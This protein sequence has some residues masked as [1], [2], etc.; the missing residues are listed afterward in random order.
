MRHVL[1][2]VLVCT[3]FL[4]P[5]LLRADGVASPV[6]WTA[7]DINGN[8]VRVP[9]VAGA[10]GP[11][12]ILFAMADQPRSRD[13]AKQLTDALKVG[14]ATVVVVVSG[15]NSA[16]GAHRFAAVDGATWPVVADPDYNASGVFN[17][18]VWPTTVVLSQQGVILG[19][20]AGLPK[21]YLSEVEAHIAL[22]AGRIDQAE[23]EHRLAGQ[24]VIGDDPEQMATRHLTVADRLL[25]KGLKREA[26]RELDAALNF[27]PN[28]PQT[29]FAMARVALA[30]GRTD[31]AV[32]ILDSIPHNTVNPAQLNLLRGKALCAQ[33]KW[34]AAVGILC[35]AV[36][37]NPQPAEAW[38][39]LG[40]AYDQLNQP[41]KAAEA[42]RRAF[43][44]TDVGRK[45]RQD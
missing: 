31:G 1:H 44:S 8:E 20:V 9:A 4:T 35:D 22:A 6:N 15:E 11:W 25:D 7:R 21:S 27:H 36:K 33:G 23:L 30:V 43:E 3:A 2:V 14:G 28:Q 38:Y 40:R 42:Y 37:L 24:S 10:A 13:A 39:S 26:E 19:H 32:A 34:E 16:D 29:Q 41:V 17:V 5:A 18:H 12:V 45:L